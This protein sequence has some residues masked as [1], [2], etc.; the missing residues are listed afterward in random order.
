ML[1]EKQEKKNKSEENCAILEKSKKKRISFNNIFSQFYLH[2]IIKQFNL[3]ANTKNQCVII[4][5]TVVSGAIVL[6]ERL[7]HSTQSV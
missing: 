1:K 7:E 4:N 6:S 2:R 5:F 3:T